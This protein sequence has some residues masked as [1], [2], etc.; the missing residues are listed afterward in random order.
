MRTLSACETMGS[1]TAICTDKTGTF[2]P[3]QMKVT[4]FWVGSDPPKQMEV[5]IAVAS[6]LRQ[7]AGLNTT[8]SVYPTEK[9]LLS[10]VVADLGMDADALK[11]SCKVLHVEAFNSD[12]KRNGVMI[13]DNAT[14]KVTAHW[15][16]AA[17]MVLAS[18]PAWP[19]GI[20]KVMSHEQ[21]TPTSMLVSSMRPCLMHSNSAPSIA[22]Q[23]QPDL[24]REPFTMVQSMAPTNKKPHRSIL[25]A[26][27]DML[28]QASTFFIYGACTEA[29]A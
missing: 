29:G 18:C 6:L 27:D 28:P 19:S 8:G 9:A 5:T 3:N 25:S 13:R 4:E 21:L 15:K 12:K 24:S 10:W 14:G 2:T 11:R 20:Y 1:V 16:G 23:R 17:E 22:H 7:G 26:P